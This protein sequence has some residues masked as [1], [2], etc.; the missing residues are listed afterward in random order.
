LLQ[1]LILKNLDVEVNRAKNRYKTHLYLSSE[2]TESIMDEMHKEV[3]IIGKFLP[4]TEFIKKI[5]QVTQK[6]VK[7]VL[8]KS[9][10]TPPSIVAVGSNKEIGK[11]PEPEELGNYF[12]MI[13]SNYNL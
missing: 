4:L 9:L 12:K 6:D 7:D 5:D 1:D 2:D 11:I 10:S 8:I 3:S 13:L